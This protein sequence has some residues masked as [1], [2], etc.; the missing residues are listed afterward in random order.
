[1]SSKSLYHGTETYSLDTVAID[2]T[3]ATA[4]LFEIINKTWCATKKKKIARPHLSPLKD[5]I[6]FYPNIGTNAKRLTRAPRVGANARLW[7][8]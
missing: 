2:S 8:A 7:D 4:S 1:M 6:Q 5:N 3:V